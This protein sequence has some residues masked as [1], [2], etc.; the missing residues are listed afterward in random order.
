MAFAPLVLAI[1]IGAI[2]GVCR[3]GHVAA[4]SGVRFASLSLVVMAVISSVAVE[5][6]DLPAPGWIA[7]GSLVMALAFAFRNMRL[8]GMAVVSV[9]IIANLVPL[10]LNGATPVRPEA[11]VEAGMVAAADLEHVT[12]S[13]PYELSDA[14]TSL[15]S[16]GDT[17]PLSFA[18]QVVSFGD[19]V[20]LVGIADVLANL[21]ARRRRPA[22]PLSALASLE[23]FGWHE[24]EEA[25][26]S[27]VELRAEMRSLYP[28]DEGEV[29][30]VFA[31]TSASPVQD[32]G[33]APPPAAESPSQY[34]ANPERTAPAIVRPR[35]SSPTSV[36]AGPR[37][38]ALQSR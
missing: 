22:V 24:A 37:S 36:S 30:R 16:L 21:L 38:R 10:V 25:S 20:I 19:I 12:L 29:V 9:G 4:L 31:N 2:V 1:V 32:C 11:L 33:V 3:G 7:L 6:L 15:A 34:S 18:K 8:A 28:E 35:N 23:A 26:G 13:G 5:H 17:I 14:D 27:I